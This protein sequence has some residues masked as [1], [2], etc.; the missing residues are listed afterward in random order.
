[1]NALSPAPEL[2]DINLTKVSA[3]DTSPTGGEEGDNST[4]NID[5]PE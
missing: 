3:R 1:M 2:R 5:K 4:T